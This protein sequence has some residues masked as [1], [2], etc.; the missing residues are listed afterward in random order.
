[1]AD[2]L[3]FKQDLAFF[4]IIITKALIWRKKIIKKYLKLKSWLINSW[5]LNQK[6]RKK[7]R[8]KNCNQFTIFLARFWTQKTGLKCDAKTWHHFFT[9]FCFSRDAEECYA[10]TL[11]FSL[12]LTQ[13]FSSFLSILQLNKSFSSLTCLLSLIFR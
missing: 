10:L 5:R 11:S 8:K 4:Y 9:A 12:S 2:W 13:C 6:R 3:T 7:K 1:M